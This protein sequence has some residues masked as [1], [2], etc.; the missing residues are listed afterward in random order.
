MGVL[1]L[2]LVL[3]LGGVGLGLAG[4]GPMASLGTRTTPRAPLETIKEFALPTANSTPEGITTGPDENL[5]FTEDILGGNHS[6]VGKIG[7][8]TPGAAS[9]SFRSLI[10]TATLLASPPG[11]MATSGLLKPMATRLA[12][13]ALGREGQGVLLGVFSVSQVRRRTSL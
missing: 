13:S 7:R 4:Y 3:V 8:I 1:V 2:V 10:P 12:G 5:W 6:S 11:R 9:P